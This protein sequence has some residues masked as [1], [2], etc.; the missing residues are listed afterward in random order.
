MPTVSVDGS[1]RKCWIMQHEENKT[2]SYMHTWASS[3]DGSQAGRLLFPAPVFGDWW[4]L[5]LV[6]LWLVKTERLPKNTCEGLV[7]VRAPWNSFWRRQFAGNHMF[8][9]IWDLEGW[10]MSQYMSSKIWNLQ[11]ELL[12]DCMSHWLTRASLAGSP[13]ERWCHRSWASLWRS[14]CGFLS[15]GI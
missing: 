7:A 5:W 14:C 3:E 6:F 12:W 4:F 15:K 8:N 2:T 1:H 13:R 9:W 10:C 11:P